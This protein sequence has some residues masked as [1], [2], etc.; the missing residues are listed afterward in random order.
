V[1]A[2]I[3]VVHH[4]DELRE[5]ALNI[6][7]GAGYE[8]AA[9][10]DP[11]IA[12]DALEPD[13]QARVLVTSVNFRP[14]QLNGVALVRMLRQKRPAIQAVFLAPLENGRHANGQGVV[15]HEPVDT[16]ALVTAV[17]ILLASLD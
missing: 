8:V 7:R 6:L 4:N 5:L 16:E 10:D 3:I 14:G 15:L 17:N 13:G 12:L 1:P 2:P 9:F 11:L